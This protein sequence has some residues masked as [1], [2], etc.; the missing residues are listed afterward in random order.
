MRE[1]YGHAEAIIEVSPN[2]VFSTIT[3][4]ERLPEWNS[5][6]GVRCS[7]GTVNADGNP[8]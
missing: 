2:A 3:D 1:I 4:I 5:E 6:D 7:Y 8:S